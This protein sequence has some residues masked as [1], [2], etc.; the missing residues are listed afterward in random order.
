M[1]DS[2]HFNTLLSFA[3]HSRDVGGDSHRWYLGQWNWA[4]MPVV[5][6]EA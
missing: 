5:P 6:F 4:E 2:F 1:A 3:I